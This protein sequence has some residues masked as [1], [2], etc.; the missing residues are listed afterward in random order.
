MLVLLKRK[1]RPL[2]YH[3]AINSVKE[4]RSSIRMRFKDRF[5]SRE[6][7]VFFPSVCVSTNWAS[8]IFCTFMCTQEQ[9]HLFLFFLF[10]Q[11]PLNTRLCTLRNHRVNFVTEHFSRVTW[12]MG[13]ISHYLW[14][15]PNFITKIQTWTDELLLNDELHLLL[16]AWIL[17]C[18]KKQ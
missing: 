18:W 13:I 3:Q 17:P 2:M 8:V 10:R 7:N 15:P 4:A 9:T 5:C 6:E 12:W 1:V 14:C 11:I 16:L